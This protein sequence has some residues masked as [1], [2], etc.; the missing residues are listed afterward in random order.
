MI[1]LLSY[2]SIGSIWV[3]LMILIEWLLGDK[4]MTPRSQIESFILWPVG[5]VGFIG[6][7]IL[8]VVNIITGR[9]L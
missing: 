3:L 9:S 1:Y 7:F 8:G 4:P 5:L 6:G 2:A